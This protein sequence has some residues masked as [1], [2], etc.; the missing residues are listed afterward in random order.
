MLKKKICA[1]LLIFTLC[2]SISAN[3][4]ELE[5]GAVMCIN[6]ET[7]EIY[8]DKNAYADMTPA[9]LT[10][11]MTLF[12][13]FEKMAEGELTED[14][15]IPVSENAATL[16]RQKGV[17]NVP[18]TA[19]S[20]VSVRTLID[21]MVIVSSCAACTVVAEYFSGSETAFAELMTK[22]AEEL[23]IRA[24]FYDAS[25]LSND[26]TITAIGLVTLVKIFITNYPEILEYTSKTSVTIDGKTYKSTNL[27][28]EASNS[29][30]SY[31]GVDG[32]KT[33]TTNKAGKCL[34]STRL[35]GDTRIICAV[36][37]A[38]TNELRYIDSIKLL[39]DASAKLNHV[40]KNLF[41]TDIRAYIN[42]HEIPCSY[43]HFGTTGV[44]VLI[45][46]LHLYGFDIEYDYATNSLYIRENTEKEILPIQR[47]KAQVPGIEYRL[48]DTNTKVFL[49]K[50][51]VLT[52][53]TNIVLTKQNFAIGLDELGSFYEKSWDGETR[54]LYVN[55][56]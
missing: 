37:K 23:G 7:G 49:E 15:L 17:T 41:S 12:V 28:L 8:Y 4:L 26:N 20:Y 25:G 3:A 22:R 24:C 2:L 51:S 11:I 48:L 13:L 56:R 27:L 33:G 29:K 21:S 40:E 32:F 46:D 10:K 35:D 43:K 9:S 5:S 1:L 44:M 19:G 47:E 50:D 45:N 54:S 53:L 31:P 16:S 36:L 18:L 34:V 14:T 38:P 6:S 42:G 52:E 30:F 55:S 39:D